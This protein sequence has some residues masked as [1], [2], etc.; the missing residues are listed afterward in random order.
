[1]NFLQQPVLFASEPTSG[2]VG[3]GL[4]LTL[5]AIICVVSL[6]VAFA[7]TTSERPRSKSTR[8][9]KPQRPQQTPVCGEVA[10]S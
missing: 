7:L 4:L 3:L 10:L 8:Q 9:D 5:T 1:M 2:L 6:V